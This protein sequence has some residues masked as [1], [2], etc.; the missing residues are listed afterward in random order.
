LEPWL[1]QEYARELAFQALDLCWDE[2]FYPKLINKKLVDLI[3]AGSK[4]ED[5]I[6]ELT[7]LSSKYSNFHMNIIAEDLLRLVREMKKLLD[8]K[9][10]PEKELY[11]V[12]GEIKP[13]LEDVLGRAMQAQPLIILRPYDEK[14]GN[15]GSHYVGKNEI[16]IYVTSINGVISLHIR[17]G[18]LAHE[19]CHL[20]M[21]GAKGANWF[22]EGLAICLAIYVWEKLNRRNLANDFLYFVEYGSA[23]KGLTQRLRKYREYW[24]KVQSI[25]SMT[26][27]ENVILQA[28]ETHK[29]LLKCATSNMS[30][31]RV[32]LRKW[33][34]D[35]IQ[36]P[37]EEVKR[38]LKTF[39][40][41]PPEER[42]AFLKKFV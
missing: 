5:V 24:Y 11:K 16:I 31:Y 7:F 33:L 1:Q 10:T 9:W 22:K 32:A 27:F 26:G 8:E 18:V 36:K 34:T 14:S 35:L 42:I 28:S 38:S 39:L 30:Y 4:A 19:F 3:K 41:Y 12:I 15:L 25:V 6:K 23:R 17:K 2:L 13:I 40:S 29:L 37:P 20:L 21:N